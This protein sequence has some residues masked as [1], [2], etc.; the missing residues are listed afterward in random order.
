MGE[1][2]FWYRPTR[3]VPDQR[4]LNDRCC[5]CCCLVQPN[6]QILTNRALNALTYFLLQI[7]VLLLFWTQTNPTHQKLKNLDPTHGS[8]QP[9]DNTA[10]IPSKVPFPRSG[11]TLLSTRFSHTSG[12]GSIDS[13]CWQ[14]SV[15]AYSRSTVS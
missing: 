11:P 3:V 5:C 1:G 15:M 14:L 4:P 9:M 7:L 8:T 10:Q 12:T 2:S 13:N 6:N